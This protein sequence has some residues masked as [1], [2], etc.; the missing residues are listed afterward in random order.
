MK[1]ALGRTGNERKESTKSDNNIRSK[2]MQ[3]VSNKDVW[4]KT[5]TI[6]EREQISS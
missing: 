3:R 6:T 4:L 2:V 1:E 5:T